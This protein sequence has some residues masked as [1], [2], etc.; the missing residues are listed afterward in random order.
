[1]T[2]E[3]SHFEICILYEKVASLHGKRS[4]FTYSNTMHVKIFLAQDLLP[5]QEENLLFHMRRKVVFLH[6]R[7]VVLLRMRKVVF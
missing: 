4:V 3:T 1:M 7:K 5:V 6:M 2:A